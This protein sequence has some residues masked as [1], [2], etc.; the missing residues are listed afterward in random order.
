MLS[1]PSKLLE[2]LVCEGLD[3][4]TTDT[5][6]LNDNQWGF[7]QGR[8]TEEL[9]IYLTETWKAALD[10]RKVVG[11]VYIDFQKAFDTVSHEI[12]IYKLQAMGF[13]GDLL[14]WMVSYLKDRKQFAEV[15]GCSSHTKPVTCGV[16]QGSLLGPRLFTYYINDLSDSVT[17]GNL[18]LYADDTT[19]YFI[20]N[21][22][23]VVVDGL[24]RALSEISLWCRNNKLTIHAG[25]SEAMII[26]HRAFCGPLRPIKLGDKILDVVYE[27]RC[28]GVIIDSQLSW[29][30]HVENLCKSFGKKVK[31]LKRFKYLPTSTLEKIYFSS[32]VPTITYCSLVWG[33]S[34]P[35]L[36]NELEHIHAR[37]AKT[38]HRLPWDISDH[39]A[40][41][42]TRWEPLSNKYK[43]KLLT[44]M[45]KVNTN[46]TPVKIAN[47][48][49]ITNPHY[50][51]RNSNHF[52]LPRYNLDIGRNSLRYRGPLVWELTPPSLKQSHSLRNFNN[53][54][55]QRHQKN[56]LNNLSFLK[57]AC[58][59]SHKK[60]DFKY[61]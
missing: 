55:K 10:N 61:F 5:G 43:K 47:F 60:Q 21:N 59:V 44:L 27:T 46:I 19:L 32:I 49:S 26:S 16:P 28:L 50:N 9:L 2:G 7:R 8:S 6:Q 13:S 15:N 14:K 45:Y 58:M 20:G 54:L 29:N 53:L 3:S 52:V 33:T 31:Q 38:I 35:S 34:T 30:S 4:F 39:N 56:F 51:L 48:F 1:L 41:E 18:E 12:L 37:A 42:R 17:E 36:M 23:D 11:V 57:E 24:N 22:V 40:L 25:K